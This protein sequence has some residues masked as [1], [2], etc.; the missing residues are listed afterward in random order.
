MSKDPTKSTLLNITKIEEFI[1]KRIR[2][3][4]PNTIIEIALS[5]YLFSSFDIGV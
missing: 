5:Q 3:S 1:N 2:V 4:F